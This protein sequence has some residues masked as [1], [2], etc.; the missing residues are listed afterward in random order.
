MADTEAIHQKL[1]SKMEAGDGAKASGTE[2]YKNSR[3]NFG[4]RKQ[5]IS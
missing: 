4:K 3:N 2:V 5:I 1:F